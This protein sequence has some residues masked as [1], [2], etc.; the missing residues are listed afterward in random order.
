MM[1]IILVWWVL[2]MTI[3]MFCAMNNHYSSKEH[4]E[5]TPWI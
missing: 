5:E 4:E 2:S 1:Y 3:G